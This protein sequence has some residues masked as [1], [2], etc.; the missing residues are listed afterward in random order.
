MKKFKFI[1]MI[2]EDQN[3]S[4]DKTFKGSFLPLVVMNAYGIFHSVMNISWIQNFMG[5]GSK[6]A[7]RT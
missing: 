7:T 3:P 2:D 1:T 5:K 6:A 4:W